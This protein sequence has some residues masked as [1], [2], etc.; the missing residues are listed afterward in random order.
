MWGVSIR[1]G[2]NLI[3]VVFVSWIL[4]EVLSFAIPL[5]GH[6]N[7]WL[8]ADFQALKEWSIF[9]GVLSVLILFVARGY[10]ESKLP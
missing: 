4:G 2:I 7:H 9:L 3:G 8:V 5:M 6:E 10:I 1:A